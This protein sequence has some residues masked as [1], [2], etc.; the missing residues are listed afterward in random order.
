MPGLGKVDAYLVLPSGLE[1]HLDEGS[2]VGRGK[3]PPF[4]PGK[5]G[6]LCA[7]RRT[8][9]VRRRDG[10]NPVAIGV[11]EE[12]G[13]ESS[14]LLFKQSRDAGAICLLGEVRPVGAE[15]LRD[16]LGLREHHDAARL[17]V[18]AVHEPHALP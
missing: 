5:P 18:E 15:L 1:L 6:G 7:A 11:F 4:G 10:A 12:M 14:A 9:R 17:A 3:P 2:A 8:A 16:L 13:L